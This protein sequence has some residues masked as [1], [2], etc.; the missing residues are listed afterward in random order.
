MRRLRPGALLA[1]LA[2]LGACARLPAPAPLTPA[3]DA[4]AAAFTDWRIAARLAVQ[5][6]DKGFSGD[7]DW[8]QAGTA[9]ELRLM[10]PLNGGTFALAG[11]SGAVSLTT[12]KGERYAARD[13]ETLMQQHLG[14]SIPLA[15]TRWWVRGLAAPG[16][17]T[18]SEVRDSAGRLTDFAQDGWRISILDYVVQDGMSLPKRLFLSHDTLKVRL[19]VKQWQALAA[20]P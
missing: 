16:S 17:G 13:A 1:L 12:P 14:W 15:G 4:R 5:R 6:D 7:L 18:A 3:D 8:R 10:A 9:F 19:A 20:P 11:D 2:L